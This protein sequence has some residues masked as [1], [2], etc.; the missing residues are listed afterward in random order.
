[1]IEEMIEVDKNKAL[2]E[3]TLIANGFKINSPFESPPSK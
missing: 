1:M 2:E 3:S